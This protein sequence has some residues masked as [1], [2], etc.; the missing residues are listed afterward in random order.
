MPLVLMYRA[1]PSRRAAPYLPSVIRR[2]GTEAQRKRIAAS[3]PQLKST[4]AYWTTA[5]HLHR[6]IA[7]ESQATITPK[8]Q[9]R[10]L[11]GFDLADERTWLQASASALGDGQELKCE[12]QRCGGR[13]RRVVKRAWNARVSIEIENVELLGFKSRV[14]LV[15]EHCANLLINEAREIGLEYKKKRYT[16]SDAP[17]RAS[18]PVKEGRGGP[19]KGKRKVSSSSPRAKRRRQKRGGGRRRLPRAKDAP[20]IE[21]VLRRI[22]ET[23]RA[24]RVS[25]DDTD[26][27]I[28]LVERQDHK[29][30]YDFRDLH[31]AIDAIDR[32]A[33]L[34]TFRVTP[35]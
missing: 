17:G 28:V 16:E 13:G 10:S 19:R 31:Q 5:V 21:R 8:S 27:F 33:L 12:I 2:T 1:E 23:D 11:I 29:F 32:P 24:S 30:R 6:G 15:C 34:R 18:S 7:C 3:S 22:L 20:D 4:T 9:H 35:T 14:Y 26:G 25:Y